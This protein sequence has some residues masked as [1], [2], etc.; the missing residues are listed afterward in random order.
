MPTEY[1]IRL[2]GHLADHWSA[3]FENMTISNEANGEGDLAARRRRGYPLVYIWANADGADCHGARRWQRRPEGAAAPAGAVAREHWL[4]CSRDRPA[5]R[6]RTGHSGAECRDG[7]A[8]A[9]L[10]CH[11]PLADHPGHD[12][13]VYGVQRPAGRGVGL[14]WLRA[15][16]PARAVRGPPIRSAHRQ[17]DPRRDPCRMASAHVPGWRDGCP[18]H[19]GND[20]RGRARDL[21]RP[22]Y[23]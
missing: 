13:A 10:G 5:D 21:A 18:E 3:W 1:H 11:A 12:R 9:D 23:P 4:V 8:R 15:A 7:S 6:T 20:H 22:A 14:A 19:P 16:T 2:K 17:P